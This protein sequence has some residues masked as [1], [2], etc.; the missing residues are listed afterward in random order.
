MLFSLSKLRSRFSEDI[1]SRI[2]GVTPHIL[3]RRGSELHGLREQEA[4]MWLQQH[5]PDIASAAWCALDDAPG[6]W[7][8]RSRLVLTDFKR[9]FTDEDAMVLRG[10]LQSFR[11][12]GA[13]P[14]RGGTGGVNGFS[15]WQDA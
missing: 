12:S 15:G 7:I 14:E 10:M 13:E 11:K 4:K 5:T 2:L 8:S 9:G 6:N 3:P 1:R